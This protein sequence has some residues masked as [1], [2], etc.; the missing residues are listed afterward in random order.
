MNVVMTVAGSV[1]TFDAGNFTVRF[2]ASIGVPPSAVT[3]TVTAASVRVVASIE[4]VDYGGGAGSEVRAVFERL[5]NITKN[6][7]ALTDAVGVTIQAVSYPVLSVQR[8]LAPSPPPPSPPPPHV[9]AGSPFAL[10]P[11]PSRPPPSSP[12]GSR[13]GIVPLLIGGVVILLG[14]GL[15]AGTAAWAAFRRRGAEA[16]PVPRVRVRNV[17]RVFMD[18]NDIMSQAVKPNLDYKKHAEHLNEIE[19]RIQLFEKM[20]RAR[21]HKANSDA[22]PIRPADHTQVAEKMKRARFHASELSI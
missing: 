15:L 20:R 17:T 21:F 1:E 8:V 9:R 16:K 6:A 14:G 10:P 19:S 7:S 13:I 2:A 18:N 11:P 22:G 5:E 3:L 12:E 4:I